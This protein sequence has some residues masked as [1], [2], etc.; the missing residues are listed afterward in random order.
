MI[1]QFRLS[2]SSAQTR[3]QFQEEVRRHEP[4][5]RPGPAS[6]GVD[7]N[8]KAC[9]PATVQLIGS[10][11]DPPRACFHALARPLR[12]TVRWDRTPP[13]SSFLDRSP[14]QSS[15]TPRP[16]R[17]LSAPGLL[18]GF[19][20]LPRH[21]RSAST[22]TRLPGP[23]YV[24]ST[25]F[26]SPTTAFSALRLGGLFHPPAMSRTHPV[27]GLLPPRSHPPSSG[28]A[29]PLPLHLTALAAPEGTTAA[30]R[31]LGFEALLRAE[32]RGTGSVIGRTGARSPPQVS[33]S[34]RCSLPSP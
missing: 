21:H 11:H 26:R 30:P 15:F 19:P 8:P 23:R 3:L 27:Q 33:V 10:L 4:V 25:G 20:A 13:G 22:H 34:P 9:M 17:C 12:P 16:A 7:R 6:R 2:P 5:T 18:L 32:M 1:K 31:R 24:P 14:L 28:G 29:A